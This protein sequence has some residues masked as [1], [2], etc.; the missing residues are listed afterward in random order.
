MRNLRE[1][2]NGRHWEKERERRNRF[3]IVRDEVGLVLLLFVQHEKEVR[4]IK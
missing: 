4:T 1:F 3:N 2:S